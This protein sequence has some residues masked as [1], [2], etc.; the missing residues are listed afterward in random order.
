MVQ[1]PCNENMSAEQ[2]VQML[3]LLA[4]VTFEYPDGQLVHTLA[5]VALEYVPAT[6]FVH[7]LALLAPATLEDLP[8]A[9]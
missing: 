2:S 9:H 8:V 4:P 3:V 1:V 6:Q 5:P 7:P